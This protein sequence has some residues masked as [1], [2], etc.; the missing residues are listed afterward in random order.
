M[1]TDIDEVQDEDITEYHELLY[2]PYSDIRVFNRT[3]DGQS[4]VGILLQEI[5]DSFLVGLPARLLKHS[6]SDTITAEAF[7]PF[8]YARLMKSNI[9]EITPVFG[10]FE[11]PYLAY[12]KEVA[13]VEY[14]EYEDFLPEG[15]FEDFDISEE[16]QKFDEEIEEKL[17]MAASKASILK[18]NKQV[19]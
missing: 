8:P 2:T 7:I 4:V 19:H 9:S 15:T 11:F 13:L 6:E 14:P 12:L 5:S 18:T 17:A 1:T 3:S 16:E 10:I